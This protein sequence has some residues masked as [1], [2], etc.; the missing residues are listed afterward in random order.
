MA[1]K[2]TRPA[3]VA[4]KRKPIV[5]AWSR[6]HYVTA[7]LVPEHVTPPEKCPCRF[8]A[9]REWLDVAANPAQRRRI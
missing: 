7:E 5:S 4:D 1:T 2:D 8:S 6:S 3:L 9:D